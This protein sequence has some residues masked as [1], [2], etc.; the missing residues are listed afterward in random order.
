M[1]C[2]WEKQKSKDQ[3][4]IIRNKGQD[5]SMISEGLDMEEVHSFTYLNDQPYQNWESQALESESM[6]CDKEITKK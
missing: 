3:L 1:L 5:N 4:L 6:D 2:L